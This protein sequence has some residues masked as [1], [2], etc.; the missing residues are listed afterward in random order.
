MKFLCRWILHQTFPS[1]FAWVSLQ[2]Q[3][4]AITGHRHLKDFELTICVKEFVLRWFSEHVIWYN[5]NAHDLG[6]ET[7]F[8]ERAIENYLSMAFVTACSWV[9]RWSPPYGPRLQKSGLPVPT[10][11]TKIIRDRAFGHNLLH[12]FS[13]ALKW[14]FTS[15]YCG[16]L[17]PVIRTKAF[18]V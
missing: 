13:G 8:V 12:E 4:L 16:V 1:N 18:N 6:A 7:F 5:L 15:L 3:H 10:R 11:K 9:L 17:A 14:F 2:Y